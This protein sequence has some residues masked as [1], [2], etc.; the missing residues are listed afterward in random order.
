MIPNR[1]KRSPHQAV[2]RPRP[3]SRLQAGSPG[4]GPSGTRAR[5]L[6]WPEL[7]ER[8]R[9]ASITELAGVPAL[10]HSHGGRILR[11]GVSAPRIVE[12]IVE[13]IVDGREPSGMSLERPGK[14][15]SMVWAK[16][17]NDRALS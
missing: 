14:G 5:V 16:Q 12:A 11:L 1:G 15:M 13:A 8:A 3:A 17:L 6:H 2:E 10:D 4:P 9:F 7:I